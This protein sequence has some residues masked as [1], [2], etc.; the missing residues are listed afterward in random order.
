MTNAGTASPFASPAHQHCKMWPGRSVA[1]AVTSD[2]I[3]DS[4]LVQYTV[5][6]ASPQHEVRDSLAKARRKAGRVAE[7]VEI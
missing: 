1:P 7:L 4:S 3:D 5:F 2:M 6:S